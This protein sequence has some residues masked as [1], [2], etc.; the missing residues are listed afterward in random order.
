[1]LLHLPKEMLRMEWSFVFAGDSPPWTLTHSFLCCYHKLYFKRPESLD[2]I[3]ST[4]FSCDAI[5][6]SW[7]SK[8]KIHSTFLQHTYLLPLCLIVHGQVSL[9]RQGHLHLCKNDFGV[10]NF[11]TYMSEYFMT[12]F[13]YV[14]LGFLDNQAIGKQLLNIHVCSTGSSKFIEYVKKTIHLIIQE[15][16]LLNIFIMRIISRH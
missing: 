16:K 14:C 1:M 10:N 7:E 4:F 11:H 13:H 15:K 6:S 9:S 3:S 5:F 2:C 8:R 12:L